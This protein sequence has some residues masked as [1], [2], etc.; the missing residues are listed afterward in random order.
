MLISYSD[1]K[2]GDEIIVPSGLNLRYYKIL[3]VQGSNRKTTL[4]STYLERHTT[5]SGYNYS[6]EFYESDVT[7]HNHKKYVNLKYR[8]AFLV[9]RESHE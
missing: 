5:S 4:V 8:H 6:N 2:D 7:K 9:K 1:L 3:K